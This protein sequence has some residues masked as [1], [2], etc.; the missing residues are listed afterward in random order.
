MITIT[1]TNSDKFLDFKFTGEMPIRKN[2]DK[3]F[4]GFHVV[5][6]KEVTV[7]IAFGKMVSGDFLQIGQKY[8]FTLVKTNAEV[9]A[10]DLAQA[11]IDAKA[12]LESG[13]QDTATFTIT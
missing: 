3:V 1:G 11:H 7:E 13:A 5:R 12:F 8:D 4:V 6:K 10:Y 2:C 9:D